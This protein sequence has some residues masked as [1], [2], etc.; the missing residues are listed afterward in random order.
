MQALE[1]VS[2][3]GNQPFDRGRRRTLSAAVMAGHLRRAGGEAA[4]CFARSIYDDAAWASEDWAAYWADVMRLIQFV[5]PG[6]GSA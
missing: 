4:L 2:A 1:T 6:P 5:P 3:L